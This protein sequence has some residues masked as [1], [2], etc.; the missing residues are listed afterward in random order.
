MLAT[1]SVATVLIDIGSLKSDVSAC[2]ISFNTTGA[3]C[4]TFGADGDLFIGNSS[5]VISRFDRKGT[6]IGTVYSGSEPVVAL[7]VKD[8][9]T[10][11][12]AFTNSVHIVNT[13]NSK[14]TG[15]PISVSNTWCA[16]MLRAAATILSDRPLVQSSP[17]V[18]PVNRFPSRQK[19]VST[20][21][22]CL[23]IRLCRLIF[24]P[25]PQHWV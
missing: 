15:A 6:H 16:I 19:P 4:A 12:V 22:T 5:G 9:R 3:T 20:F 7:A 24:V 10:L 21:T 14:I 2:K 17:F 23:T 1:S 13:T 8:N 25:S 11:V 18:L